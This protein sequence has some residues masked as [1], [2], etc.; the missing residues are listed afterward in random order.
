MK[1]IEFENVKYSYVDEDTDIPAVNGV[2][3][4]VESGE[5]VAVLG[6]NGSGKSTIAKL[7]NGIYLPTE[8]KVFVKGMDTADESKEFEVRS[9]AGV[10]LQNP[11]NQIVASIVEEDVA[12]GPENLGIPPREIRERVDNALKAVGMTEY[13]MHET[14]RLS[15]GQKQ[16]VAIAGIIAMLPECIILDEP[17]AMLDPQGRLEVMSVL[18]S[19]CRES[20]I[21]I[22]LITHNMEEAVNA[23]R[24][25]VMNDGLIAA[26]GTPHEIFAKGDMLVK[27]GL[28]VPEITK[29]AGLVRQAG[30]DFPAGVLTQEEFTEEYIKMAEDTD[31]R[32]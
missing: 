32:T 21:A 29:I 27:C 6:H 3:F 24:I 12:F 7:S 8:G 28:A 30:I 19:L 10:V 22:I 23:D 16:R 31:A 9:T 1:L 2:S 13:A 4:S 14:H 17:T 15:G 26:E 20:N 18:N 5:F 25:I 11:D